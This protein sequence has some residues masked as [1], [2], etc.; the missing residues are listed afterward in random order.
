MQTLRKPFQ[1][2]FWEKLT[3]IKDIL[4]YQHI[5]EMIG[6]FVAEKVNLFYLFMK[7]NK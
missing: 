2:F 4:E 6:L 1:F 5:N 3:M 7:L